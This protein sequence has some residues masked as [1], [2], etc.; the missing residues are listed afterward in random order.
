MRILVSG[1]TATLRAVDDPRFGVLVVPGSRSNPEALPLR[2]GAWAM[3]NAGFLGVDRPAFLN[4]LERYHPT[5]TS[6]TAHGSQGCLFVTAPD[7]VFKWAETLA[8][9]P[10]WSQRSCAAWATRRRSSPRT[11]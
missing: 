11:G 10:F 8:Q 3:D 9:W 4:M 1:A 5:Q 7:V 2:P 6:Q